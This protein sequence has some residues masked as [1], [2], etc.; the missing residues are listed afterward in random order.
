VKYSRRTHYFSCQTFINR[1]KF[2]TAHFPRYIILK[3]SSPLRLQFF[4]RTLYRFLPCYIQAICQRYANFLDSV[5][6]TGYWVNLPVRFR[7]FSQ[8][9]IYYLKISCFLRF[10]TPQYNFIL[11]DIVFWGDRKCNYVIILRI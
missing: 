1:V 3:I 5:I 9:I 11:T 6:K 7:N 2:L 4:Y 10:A 8:F